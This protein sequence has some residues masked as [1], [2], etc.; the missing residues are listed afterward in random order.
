MKNTITNKTLLILAILIIV[1]QSMMVILEVAGKAFL[2]FS[3][4]IYTINGFTLISLGILNAI[5][6]IIL[7]ILYL[8]KK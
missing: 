6:L 5:L 7:I 3:T 2:N 8:R 1:I 4:H